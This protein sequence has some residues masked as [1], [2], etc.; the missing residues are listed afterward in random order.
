M[1][2]LRERADDGERSWSTLASRQATCSW[3]MLPAVEDGSGSL[4]PASG[5][6]SVIKC[7]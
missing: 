2:D 7:W 4:C 3:M 6:A 1:A 5:S